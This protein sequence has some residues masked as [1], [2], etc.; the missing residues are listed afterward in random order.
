MI[1]ATKFGNV[2]DAQGNFLGVNGRL[3]YVRDCC[4]ASLQRLGVE[5]IDLY[6]QCGPQAALERERELGNI[7]RVHQ[8]AAHGGESGD[9]DFIGVAPRC[10]AQVDPMKELGA[11]YFEKINSISLMVGPSVASRMFK[12]APALCRANRAWSSPMISLG[13]GFRDQVDLDLERLVQERCSVDPH[14]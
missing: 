8:F 1:L 14:L 11:S 3:E 4:E 10:D 12:A 13:G 6:Y 2:R 5:Q 7:G 9:G